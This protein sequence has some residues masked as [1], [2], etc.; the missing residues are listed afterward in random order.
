[1]KI[2][3]KQGQGRSRRK[4][5][6]REVS[7][8]K[9]G[10]KIFKSVRQRRNDARKTRFRG[11]GGNVGDGYGGDDRGVRPS[12]GRPRATQKQGLNRPTDPKRGV[13][14][15]KIAGKQK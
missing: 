8:Y 7:G 11:G 13:V 10:I 9:R 4:G 2:R 5:L 15:C 3:D 14:R 1:M 12:E 6:K